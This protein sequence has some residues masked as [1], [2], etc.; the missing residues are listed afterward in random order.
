LA[1]ERP[2]CPIRLLF[3]FSFFGSIHLQMFGGIKTAR[4]PC[5]SI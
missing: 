5:I 2:L 4:K 1:M 3:H